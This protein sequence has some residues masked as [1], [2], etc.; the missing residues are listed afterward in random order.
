[1]DLVTIDVTEVPEAE[2][3]DE[4]V[5]LGRQG[6][7]EITVEELAAKLDTISYEV[8]CSVSARVPRVYL[9]GGAI[10]RIRTRFDA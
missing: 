4:V 2:P 7:D 10:T 6:S 5:L 9:D 1:M 3:G 8:F